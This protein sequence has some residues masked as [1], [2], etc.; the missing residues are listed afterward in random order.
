MRG[1][2]NSKVHG[3]GIVVGYRSA[4]EKGDYRGDVLVM[5]EDGNLEV[6]SDVCRCMHC[7]RTCSLQGAVAELWRRY[8]YMS[9]YP[10]IPG[11]RG[12]WV[13]RDDLDEETLA[14]AQREVRR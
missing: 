8:P 11:T 12:K 1:T 10:Y 6:I 14:K 3:R 9:P 5:R 4:P 13:F 7:V 2:F